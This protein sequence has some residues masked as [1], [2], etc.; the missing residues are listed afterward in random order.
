MVTYAACPNCLKMN[1]IDIEKAR[2][3]KP[4]CGACHAEID[5]QNG[6]LN[7]ST[8]QVQKMMSSSPLLTVVD[9]WAPWCAPCRAFAPNFEQV[10]N[11]MPQQAA[12]V[13]LNTENHPDASTAFQIRGIPTVAAFRDGSEVNR[14]SGA[15]SADQFRS[16]VQQSL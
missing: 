11:Q 15:T 10:A 12:F 6:V 16:W 1:K 13:K 7:A 9:F 3:K 14:M 8:R 2:G 4:V 5:F